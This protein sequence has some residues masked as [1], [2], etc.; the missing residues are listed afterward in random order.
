MHRRAAT[1]PV[2]SAVAA[3]QYASADA[4]IQIVDVDAGR[5][6]TGGAGVLAAKEQL[7]LLR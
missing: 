5:V 6:A 4:G 1:N 7:S 2:A 3:K